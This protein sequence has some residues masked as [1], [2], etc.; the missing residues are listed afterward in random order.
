LVICFDGGDVSQIFDV[1]A[2]GGGCCPP[3]HPGQVIQVATQPICLETLILRNPRVDFALCMGPA[4]CNVEWL[5]SVT[6]MPFTTIKSNS[7]VG[8]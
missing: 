6:H 2:V 4:P 8:H 7:K 1:Q 3:L 5:V